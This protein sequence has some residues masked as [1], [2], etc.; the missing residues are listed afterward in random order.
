MAD[1]LIGKVKEFIIFAP[2]GALSLVRD[3][4]PAVIA[5]LV[6]RGKLDEAQSSHHA[7]GS[8]VNP[9]ED[10]SL[11]K[12]R[13][14]AY[15]S[16][17]QKSKNMLFNALGSVQIVKNNLPMVQSLTNAKGKQVAQE[18]IA[19]V[20][21]NFFQKVGDKIKNPVIEE[22][23][24][25]VEIV[26]PEDNLVR[27]V[28]KTGVQTAQTASSVTLGVARSGVSA[29]KSIVSTSSEASPC[30]DDEISGV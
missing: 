24:P 10:K 9:D 13:M 4:A 18:N 17:I 21:K 8:P 11:V 16:D 30:G 25:P 5:L 15:T 29:L 2:R 3:T 1:S 12:K 23:P 14:D 20:K 19:T 28:V 7:P 26:P 22:P 27:S 6:S